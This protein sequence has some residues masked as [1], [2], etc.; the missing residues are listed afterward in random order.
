[1]EQDLRK[2]EPL[3]SSM[4]VDPTLQYKLDY[5]FISQHGYTYL[6]FRFSTTFV[7]ATRSFF[8]FAFIRDGM[9]SKYLITGIVMSQILGSYAAVAVGY[10]SDRF[11]SSYGR[12]KPFIGIGVCCSIIANIGLSLSSS[13]PSR[14]VGG[15]YM[16]FT[17]FG[18][19][20]QTISI[21]MSEPWVLEITSNQNEFLRLK[22]YYET[23][24]AAVSAFIAGLIFTA[25]GTTPVVVI[26]TVLA[27][28]F[29]LLLFFRVR[30]GDNA[31]IYPQPPLLPA[32]RIAWSNPV[33]RDLIIGFCLFNFGHGIAQLQLLTLLNFDLFKTQSDLGKYICIYM[34]VYTYECI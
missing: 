9:S 20:G 31:I 3:E 21:V 24:A 22:N 30:T 15:L 18:V 28:V 25:S 10:Y 27:I 29:G 23:P 11:K 16:I 12:R 4:S 13:Q 2:S 1:M 32:I 5:P 7:A 33:A 19:M 34:H 8:M 14:I 6:A 26:G 17:S